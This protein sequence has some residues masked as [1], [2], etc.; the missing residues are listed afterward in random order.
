MNTRRLIFNLV[1][2]V[3]IL[4]PI[5]QWA[6]YRI[7][8]SRELHV[9]IVDKT[10][11][12]YARPEHRS[13]TWILTH[14]K[15]KKPGNEEYSITDD[16]F[17]FFP[18]EGFD[19][20]IQDFQDYSPHQLD[21]LSKLYDM[22]YVADAYG[23]Y[24]ND[25]YLRANLTEPSPLIYGGL[26]K[27]ELYLMKSFYN[28]KKLLIAEFNAIAHPTSYHVR[29][30]AE[31]LLGLNWTGWTGRFFHSFDTLE[32]QE[33]PRWIIRLYKEQ[34]NG[35]WPFT[36]SGIVFVH[37]NA[38]ICILENGTHLEKD[39]PVITTDR[40]FRREY[41]LPEEFRYS[42]WFDI[43]VPDLKKNEII[44]KYRIQPNEDGAR[45][46]RKFRIPSTFPAAMR[47]RYQ[48][49]VF[50]FAGDFADNNIPDRFVKMEG[51]TWYYKQFLDIQDI[52][53]RQVFFWEYYYPMMTRILKRYE[54]ENRTGKSN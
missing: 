52:Y 11:A 9:L 48:Q 4:I 51:I 12:E 16:Y 44:S 13:L 53:N 34:N 2:I 49:R 32:N 42:F 50:Y 25:W 47:D 29:R 22:M 1:I 14:K 8:C 23:V 54:K 7:K 3:I 21:S 18:G 31:E 35:Q 38:T 27:K 36:E 33:L 10:A 26:D 40:E 28:S 46:L 41:G 6:I 43:T 19:Y 37:E 39:I 45:E 17:G 5:L 30:E 15:Y 20:T 24:Y